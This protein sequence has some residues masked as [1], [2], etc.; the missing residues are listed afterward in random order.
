MGITATLPELETP[1]VA[2]APAAAK[3]AEAKPVAAKPAETKP[4]E[5]KSVA[6]GQ[7]KSAT[8]VVVT[9]AEQVATVEASFGFPPP[10]PRRHEATVSRVPAAQAR[11]AR[12][13][14]VA[15]R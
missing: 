1:V 11:K 10:A 15:K 14:P 8:P 12:Q 5:V 4:V 6:D 2:K 3:L 7:P 13:A 9:P